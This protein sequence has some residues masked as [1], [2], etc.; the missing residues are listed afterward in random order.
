[1][2][3]ETKRYSDYMV[4]KVH[5]Y[6]ISCGGIVSGKGLAKAVHISESYAQSCA[7][8]AINRYSDI[9]SVS[10]SG[11]K[12]KG[13]EF[14][15]SI[16]ANLYSEEANDYIYHWDGPT[17]K[18]MSSLNKAKECWNGWWP[19]EEDLKKQIKA[20]KKEHAGDALELEIGLWD[21]EGNELEFLN[22]SAGYYE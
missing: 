17:F 10:G 15:Y 8:E 6:L 7:R 4:D 1:M 19:P 18:R 22:M 21:G 14:S 3:H 5:D 20:W 16:T 11:Y 13:I 9:E 2:K 12:K